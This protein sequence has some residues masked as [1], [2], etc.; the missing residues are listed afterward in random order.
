MNDKKMISYL[1]TIDLR[2]EE[3]FRTLLGF[4]IKGM[5]PD[6]KDI[7]IKEIVDQCSEMLN[8]GVPLPKV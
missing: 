2:N 7:E 5:H 4:L 8:S 6:L 1:N 3:R